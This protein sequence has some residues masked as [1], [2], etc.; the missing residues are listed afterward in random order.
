MLAAHVKD[1]ALRADLRDEVLKL[2]AVE[3]LG[4]ELLRQVV[5]RGDDGH[6]AGPELP[7]QA[8]HEDGLRD[9]R[10]VQLIEE[11][12]PEVPCQ[13]V[14]HG[15]KNVHA[16]RVMLHGAEGIADELVPMQAPGIETVRQAAEEEVEEDRLAATATAVQ[17]GAFG[18]VG[19]G[20]CPRC[21]SAEVRPDRAPE[22]RRE[23]SNLVRWLLLPHRLRRRQIRQGLGVGRNDLVVD[24]PENGDGLQ[25][26]GIPEEGRVGQAVVGAFQGVHRTLALPPCSQHGNSDV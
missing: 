14:A 6:A 25:L 19:F 4:V 8:L 26:Q 5:G 7:E 20:S 17:V 23:P 24:G 1:W 11:E 9:V 10:H 12:D 15:L 21:R 3:A 22:E 2:V 13:T 16:A 18:R